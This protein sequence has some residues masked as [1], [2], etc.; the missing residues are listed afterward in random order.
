M[1]DIH[2]MRVLIVDDMPS[3]CKFI[4]KMMK[5]IGHGK[6]FLFANSG[7]EALDILK[8][9]SIDLVLLD[10]NMPEMSGSEV[11]NSIRDDMELRDTPV[12]MVTAEAYS[13]FVAE[14]GESEV[15][16]YILKPITMKFLE[17]KVSYVVNKHNNPPPMLY[18]LKR[19][20]IFEDAGDLD[21]A[22]KEAHLAR[23]AN[24]DVTRPIR[25]LGYYYYHKNKLE[26]AEKW[27]LQ[28]AERNE[29]DVIA[30]HYLGEIY[31]KYKDIEKAA[32]YLE[33]AMK[34]SPRHIERGLNFGKTLVHMKIT[35]KAVQIFDKILGCAGNPPELQEEIADFCIAEEVH[36]YAVKLLKILVKEQPNR[37]D[38]LLKLAVTLEKLGDI[39]LAITYL[40]R[41]DEIDKENV[42]I[43]IRLAKNYLAL[44]KP[45][46]A[47]RPLRA[48]INKNPEN[49]LA[50]ELLKQCV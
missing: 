45:I 28:A 38:L 42:D 16:A 47:E 15:D 22:I 20:R 13:D 49:E 23:K 17:E 43:K 1:I 48:I 36:E 44:K 4:H 25:E 35:P 11:L 29:L 2:E 12:I 41:A 18:H 30:F 21:S 7:K 19:A 26:E 37:A 10:F 8:K 27:L 46:L 33:K 40:N 32:Y 39:S 9:E 5:N 14:V 31:L 50:Q 3:M 6:E 24:P 34:I